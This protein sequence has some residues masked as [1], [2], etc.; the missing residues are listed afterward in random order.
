MEIG[1]WRRG[2]GLEQYETAFRDD[3]IDGEVL[4]KLTAN[5]L[6][7]IEV[8]LVG[9]SLQLRA[10]AGSTGF[11]F[12]RKRWCRRQARRKSAND[13]TAP[14]ALAWVSSSGVVQKRE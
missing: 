11:P 7:D 5:D 6:K 8:V 13:P 9:H 10:H 14:S 2:L 12:G 3:A 4:P 1:G